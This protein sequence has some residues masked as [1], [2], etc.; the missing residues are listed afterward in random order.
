MI[1]FKVAGRIQP[2]QTLSAQT[3]Q[4]FVVPCD[5]VSPKRVLSNTSRS[6]RTTAH[7]QCLRTMGAILILLASVMITACSTGGGE[8][9]V[10][11]TAPMP[12]T[13]STPGNDQASQ[14]ASNKANG[15]IGVWEG[16][17][18]ASCN[19]SSPTR[20]NAQE[21]VTLTFIEGTSG[22]TGYYRCAYSTMD[23]LGQN[24]TG[25]VANASLNGGQI[26]ARVEMPDGTSCLYTGHTADNIVNG[27]YS[28]YAGGSLIESGSWNARRTY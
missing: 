22:V 18:L 28:C 19:T 24:E 1:D 16:L 5:E 14:A 2:S 13:V 25:K 4:G 15:V 12:G 9:V 23:C 17:T 26:T 27:G 11:P 21:K 20:C 10:Y 6:V 8:Q 3:P 7:Q